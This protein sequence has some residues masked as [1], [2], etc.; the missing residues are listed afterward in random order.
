MSILYDPGKLQECIEPG[1]DVHP[2]ADLEGEW[3]DRRH[4]ELLRNAVTKTR[5]LLERLEASSDEIEL[6]WNADGEQR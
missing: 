1:S 2:K 6:A 3:D 4:L 5:E